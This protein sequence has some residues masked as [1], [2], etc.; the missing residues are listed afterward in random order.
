MFTAVLVYTNT[1]FEFKKSA[2][3]SLHRDN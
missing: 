3:N 2:S 1:Q